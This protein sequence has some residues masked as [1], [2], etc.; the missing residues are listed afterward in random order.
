MKTRL[1]KQQS[2]WARASKL[3]DKINSLAARS[4]PKKS[5]ANPNNAKAATKAFARL[6]RAKAKARS[7]KGYNLL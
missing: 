6:Y 4:G 7:A 1:E 5:H 3:H 2:F